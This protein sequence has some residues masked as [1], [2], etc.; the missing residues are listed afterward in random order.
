MGLN[1]FYTYNGQILKTADGNPI[2]YEYLWYEDGLVAKY[3]FNDSLA[4]ISGNGYDLSVKT[5]SV[6][7]TT[8]IINKAVN[9]NGSS[10][11]YTNESEILNTF[12]GNGEWTIALFTDYH[13]PAY[14]TGYKYLFFAGSNTNA[15]SAPKVLFQYDFNRNAQVYRSQSSPAVNQ[16]VYYSSIAKNIFMHI[17][18]TF[19]DGV[20][21]GYY[22][23]SLLS[24]TSV[25]T[26]ELTDDINEF[27]LGY[28][29]NTGNSGFWIGYLD[30]L[31]IYNRALSS[32]EISMLYNGGAG[33]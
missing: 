23:G 2:G 11:I 7:Y 21:N 22:N 27:G 29:V 18:A 28:N 19:K 31:Y 8:G 16:S 33:M 30:L 15:A 12:R 26:D 4:D 9:L 17:A 6:S 32:D 1:R 14:Y 13:S 20:L 25:D 3:D 5:G 10:G 24:S